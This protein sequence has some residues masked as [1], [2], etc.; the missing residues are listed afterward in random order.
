LGCIDA[1]SSL[2]KQFREQCG[3][4]TF[5]IA[6]KKLIS[7]YRPA[8]VLVENAA[9]GPA[10]LSRLRQRFPHVNFV[11][12]EPK[13]SKSERLDRHRKLIA[14]GGI[15]I[16]QSEPWVDAFVNEFVHH[17][18]G[19]TDQVDA[20]TQLLDY[21]E[22]RPQLKSPAIFAGPVGIS[23]S[24]LRPIVQTSW[25]NGCGVPGIVIARSAP[26]F[27]KW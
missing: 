5:E 12:I 27:K 10:L 25:T 2:R 24:T 9:N 21:L 16:Q 22:T 26:F 8:A 1:A 14:S 3:F 13:G 15:S 20:T 19:G 6:V 23:A 4:A 18:D 7:K 11:A 17:P